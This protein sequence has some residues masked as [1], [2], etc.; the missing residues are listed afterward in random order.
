MLVS[1]GAWRK[2]GSELDVDLEAADQFANGW[3]WHLE[4][5]VRVPWAVASLV[6]VEER[7]TGHYNEGVPSVVHRGGEIVHLLA[8]EHE[9]SVF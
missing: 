2:E 3:I 1:I 4:V 6:K 5:S 8:R 9:V 7:S